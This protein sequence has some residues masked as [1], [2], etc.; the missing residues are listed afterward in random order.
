MPIFGIKV[1]L[2]NRTWRSFDSSNTHDTFHLLIWGL[3]LIEMAVSV[4]I[5][6]VSRSA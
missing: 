4:E 3:K 6:F 2:S 1:E 5:R